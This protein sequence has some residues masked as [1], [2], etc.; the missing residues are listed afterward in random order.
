MNRLKDAIKANN[1]GYARGSIAPMVDLQYG[2]QMGFAPQYSELVN[3]AAGVRQDL[4]C[5]LLDYPHGFDLFPEK[6]DWIKTLRQLVEVHPLS[7]TGL[8]ATLTVAT[9]SSPVGGSG[10]TQLDP[11]NVTMEPINVQMRWS[12]KY[13]SPVSKFWSSYIRML[14]KDPESKV[15]GVATLGANRPGDMLPNMRAFSMAFIEPDV[16]H[17]K[18][19]RSWVVTN[20]FPQ[21]SGD[22]IGQRDRTADGEVPDI[23]I[24]MG[25]IGQFG[26]GVDLFCQELLDGIDITGANPLNRPS[27][28][29]KIDSDVNT[30]GRGYEF[31]A[32]ELGRTAYRV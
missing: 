5:L 29:D 7:V 12:E 26:F 1:T 22:I 16:L 23:T 15:P 9:T 2:G 18:V 19:I 20:M 6:Q 25:G 30:A 21:G 3:N 24:S 32:E 17:S 31:T 13:G 11:T 10:Q 28:I 8:N 14:I 4:I 27:H